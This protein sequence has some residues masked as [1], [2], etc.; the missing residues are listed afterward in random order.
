[1]VRVSSH[2]TTGARIAA[3]DRV[4]VEDPQGD[5]H[6]LLLLRCS[7][8]P[9]TRTAGR[10]GR[11]PAA[12][13]ASAR[14]PRHRASAAARTGS[15]RVVRLD[16]VQVQARAADCLAAPGRVGRQP[17]EVRRERR[18]GRVPSGPDRCG[19]PLALDEADQRVGHRGQVERHRAPPSALRG[20]VPAAQPVPAAGRRP[21][22]AASGE[23]GRDQP[24]VTG[25]RAA[26]LGDRRCRRGWRD[27]GDL[28]RADRDA[29]RRAGTFTCRGRHGGAW[30]PEQ[31]GVAG[32][33]SVVRRR[34]E[35]GGGGEAPRVRSD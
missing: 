1:M 21:S 17:G 23:G 34:W 35:A 10:T 31:A 14:P 3:H 26:A 32:E 13:T 8:S 33:V 18:P 28:D 20:P 27:D 2:G 9:S 7:S 22:L 29:R 24:R 6:R 4:G 19:R 11:A 30:R 25:R 12:G 5:A 15:P 16:V